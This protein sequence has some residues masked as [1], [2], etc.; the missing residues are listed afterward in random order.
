[1][2]KVLWAHFNSFLANPPTAQSCAAAD[3]QCEA[4]P[5]ASHEADG[6]VEPPSPVSLP[7]ECIPI[8]EGPA[9]GHLFKAEELLMNRRC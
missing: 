7:A 6:G 2:M 5:A 3:A 1:M 8:K 9:L 4:A